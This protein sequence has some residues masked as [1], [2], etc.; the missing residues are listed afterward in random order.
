TLEAEPRAVSARRDFRLAEF[1]LVLPA[2]DLFEQGFV[3]IEGVA[4][5]IDVRDGNCLTDGERALIGLLL[6][7]DHAEQRRFADAVAAD[8]ADDAATR[9]VEVQVVGQQ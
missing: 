3:G 5:L 9:Q 7:D 2:G 8:Y 1:D 4:A 6:T